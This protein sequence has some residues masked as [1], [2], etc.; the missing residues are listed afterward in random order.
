MDKT[1]EVTVTV[2]FNGHRIT[3]TNTVEAASPEMA[4][5]L[6]EAMADVDVEIASGTPREKEAK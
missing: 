5:E 6:A 3:R 4:K 2:S 1:Y